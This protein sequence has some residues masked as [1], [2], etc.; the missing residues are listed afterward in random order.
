MSWDIA[1]ASDEWLIDL[2]HKA[3]EEGGHIGGPTGGDQAVKLS[4]HIAAK[5][6]LGV[7]APEAAMQ[8]FAYN[9]VDRNIV[10]VP[11]VYRYLESKQRDP[12]GYLFME[13]IPG[14]NLLDVDLEERKDILPRIANII[15]HLGQIKGLTP[16]PI[17]G[18]QP[19]GYIYGDYGARTTFK[20]MED[21]NV[22]MNSRLQPLNSSTPSCALSWRHLP[23]KYHS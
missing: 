15:M 5:F 9:N 12:H 10:R 21:M 3:N 2:C 19:V 16:G 17:T 1:T 18:A 7:C 8:E 6:G 11:K 20:S 4:D 14:Q 13:Y 23:K 22:Y